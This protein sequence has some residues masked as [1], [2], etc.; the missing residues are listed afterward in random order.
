MAQLSSRPEVAVN[1][2]ART[3][4][5]TMVLDTSVDPET[6]TVERGGNVL[7]VKPVESWKID[8][9]QTLLTKLGHDVSFFRL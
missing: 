7:M 2:Q 4:R 1:G 3:M 5:V 8:D 6:L 9:L